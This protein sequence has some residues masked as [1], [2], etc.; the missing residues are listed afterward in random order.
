LKAIY[1]QGL[2]FLKVKVKGTRNIVN[3]LTLPDYEILVAKLDRAGNIA[4][5]DFRDALVGVS[6]HQLFC[7]AFGLKFG[8]EDRQRL[9]GARLLAKYQHKP[10]VTSNFQKWGAME[11]RD[12]AKLTNKLKTAIGLP[13]VSVDQFDSVQMAAWTVGQVLLSIA[14]DELKKT[15]DEALEFVSNYSYNLN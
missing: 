3:A 7:D 5:Q 10:L 15:A 8:S 11:G 9:I 2:T 1:G 13:L 12:Y 6:L 4:A 14:A